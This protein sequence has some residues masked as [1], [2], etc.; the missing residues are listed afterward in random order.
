M[1]FVRYTFKMLASFSVPSCSGGGCLVVKKWSD[2]WTASVPRCLSAYKRSAA[3]LGAQAFHRAMP[4]ITDVHGGHLRAHKFSALP[5]LE[6]A[7]WGRQHTS[8]KYEVAAKIWHCIANK[9]LPVANLTNEYPVWDLISGTCIFVTS[10]QSMRKEAWCQAHLGDLGNQGHRPPPPPPTNPP[11]CYRGYTKGRP[12]AN[13][14]LP[15]CWK[16]RKVMIRGLTLALPW[17]P[18]LIPFSNAW[19]WG[20]PFNTL[21]LFAML[22]VGGYCRNKTPRNKET[23]KRKDAI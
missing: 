11:P 6:E 15:W 3:N 20:Y 19:D 4:C 16:D 9:L 12:G 17:F 8:K 14:V 22:D 10:M 7:L 18:S 1:H 5:R 23:E 2:L 13:F 21:Q